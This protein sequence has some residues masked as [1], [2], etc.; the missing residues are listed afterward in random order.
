VIDKPTTPG[1]DA[2]AKRK[3]LEACA[4]APRTPQEAAFLAM[5]A[6][7]QP[8]DQ[9]R[10]LATLRAIAGPARREPGR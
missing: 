10:V 6:E 9:A 8:E 7:V 3:T 5:L 1:A 2:W 4:A